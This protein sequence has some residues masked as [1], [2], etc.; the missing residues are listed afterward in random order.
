[1]EDKSNNLVKSLSIFYFVVAFLEICGEFCKYHP[2][3]L[4]AKPLLPVILM[5]LYWLHSEK[6]Q[7]LF[8]ISMFFSFLTNIF[9]I[10]NSSKMLFYGVIAFAFHRI[11]AILLVL[12]FTKI[13]DFIPFLI[14]TIPFLLIFFYL[15]AET[16]DIPQDSFVLLIFQNLLIAVYSGIA[17]SNYVMNDNKQNSI[18]L[19][20]ALLFVMLQFV[21]FIE[22]YYLTN[23]YETLFRPVA[24]TLNT[25]AFYSFY[26]YAITA[27]NSNN[28]G[29]S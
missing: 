21:V 26:K 16:E 15:F 2:F 6:K 14:A 3:I 12:K 23:E 5:V 27:E 7:W 1:M 11:F 25:L 24:M 9:F 29:F 13:K 10:P 19:I 22:K 18:F 8:F 20:S 28:N 17:L 4:V